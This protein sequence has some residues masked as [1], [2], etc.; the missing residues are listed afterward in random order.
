MLAARGALVPQAIEQLALLVWLADDLD[1][2]V[3]SV[4][5]E[6]IEA[7]R[8]EALAG[9]LARSDVPELMRNHLASRGVGPDVAPALGDDP[10]IEIP[11]DLPD[12]SEGNESASPTALS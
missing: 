2:E 12:T 10:L 8:A 3:A 5:A 9:F 11:T 4:A 7:I 1:P 6:T